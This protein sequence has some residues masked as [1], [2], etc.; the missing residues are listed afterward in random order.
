MFKWLFNIIKLL[1]VAVVIFF[2]LEFEYKGRK[3]KTYIA[4]FP[5]SIIAL[6]TKYYVMSIITGKK[7]LEKEKKLFGEEKK[8]EEKPVDET[9]STKLKSLII[10][11]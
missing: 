9:E 11:N 2:A 8:L 3:V 6:R 5:N 10:N 1:I 4:E 7:D